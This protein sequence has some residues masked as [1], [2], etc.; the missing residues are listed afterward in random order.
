M[1]AAQADD[2]GV[3]V[4][5]VVERQAARLGR[6][7][8]LVLPD[9]TRS[10]RRHRRAGNRLADGLR[11]LGHG[12]GDIV[13]ARCG[14]GVSMVATWFACMKLGA[15]FMPVNGLLTGEPLRRGDGPFRR[16]GGGMRR[17]ALPGA[18][19]RAQ[20]SAPAP[21]GHRGHG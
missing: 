13:M 7:P 3:G 10:Q 12:P 4:R 2:R 18:G 5:A 8:F 1:V 11:R 21:S 6:R 16:G 15:V 14:N 19:R 17:R 20:R 9:A